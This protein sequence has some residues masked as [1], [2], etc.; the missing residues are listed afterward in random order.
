[1]MST[2]LA[3][4]LISSSLILAMLQYPQSSSFKIKLD[5]QRQQREEQNLL[6]SLVVRNISVSPTAS[7]SFRFSKL[8]AISSVVDCSGVKSVKS[9]SDVIGMLKLTQLSNRNTTLLKGLHYSGGKKLFI[10]KLTPLVF[11]KRPQ[12]F[13]CSENI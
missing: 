3:L 7:S 12:S 8:I 10:I 11:T 9:I 13:R 4:P 6:L 5:G 1:M 2:I